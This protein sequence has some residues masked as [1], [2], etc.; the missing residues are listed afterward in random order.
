M[1]NEQLVEYTEKSYDSRI[2][3][4]YTI[5]KKGTET[6]KIILEEY[7]KLRNAINTLITYTIGTDKEL[8]PILFDKIQL[9]RFPFEYNEIESYQEKSTEDKL[10]FLE[11]QNSLISRKINELN[12]LKQHCEKSISK[13]KKKCIKMN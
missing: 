12:E 11:F 3:K 8:L 5:T 1:Y 4:I 13:F 2:R 10:E 9:F 6:L 7:L